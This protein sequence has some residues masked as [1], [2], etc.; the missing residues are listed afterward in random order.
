MRGKFLGL[1][2]AFL[3]DTHTWRPMEGVRSVAEVL[4]LIASEGYGPA[5][6]LMGGIGNDIDDQ[7][8]WRATRQYITD[9]LDVLKTACR[10]CSVSGLCQGGCVYMALDVQQAEPGGVRLP[11]GALAARHRLQ[12][13][14]PQPSSSRSRDRVPEPN[15]LDGCREFVSSR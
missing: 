12:P 3:E 13:Q 15:R 4:M 7:A 8:I 10:G 1:A 6:V 11:A 9:R 5:A 2:D 14:R